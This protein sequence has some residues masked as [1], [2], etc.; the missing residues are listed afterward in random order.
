MYIKL[1]ES[2]IYLLGYSINDK[3][4]IGGGEGI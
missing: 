3:P 2:I 1:N 4:S